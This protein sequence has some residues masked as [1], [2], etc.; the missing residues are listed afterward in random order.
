[1]ARIARWCPATRRTCT[2][3]W[4][5]SVRC[6]RSASR[7]AL[8]PD[9]DRITMPAPD[10]PNTLSAALWRLNSVHIE[11]ADIVLRRPSLDDVFLA[12]TADPAAGHRRH[13]H[14]GVVVTALTAA[15][16]TPSTL[17]QWWVLTT[18]MIVPTLR[19]GEVAVGIAASVATTAC[20]YI[21]LNRLMAGPDLPMSSYAQYLLPLIVL[22]AIAFASVST[23]FRAATD[24][25]QGLNRRLAGAADRAADPAGRPGSRPVSIVVR[26]DWPSR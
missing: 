1:M 2:P 16:P 17:Q 18:R 19:N 5:R 7:A 23:A 6:C 21:P 13:G 10:G 8:T 3:W 26:S 14:R 12:L 9:S 15:R 20:F 11:L 22:Q 24:A 25:V 4:M